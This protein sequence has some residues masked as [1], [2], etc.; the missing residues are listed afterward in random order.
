[1]S[2]TLYD[3]A[4]EL[5]ATGEINWEDDT[6]YVYLVT[7]GYTPVTASHKV[8]SD[9]SS[10]ARISGPVSLSSKTADAGAC[11]AGDVTFSSVTADDDDDEVEYI[12]IAK[13]E[14]TEDDS[15][16]IA[17][18]DTATGLPITPNG[19]DI[20]VTWDSGTNKIFRL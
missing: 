11:D 9:V 1:M 6:F 12:I 8:I 13:W 4:R 10:S 18:I 20:I 14:N 3:N 7:G 19:G 2:N 15:P 5:F 16:L 17:I